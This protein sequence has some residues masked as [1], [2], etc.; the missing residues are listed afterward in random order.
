M[1]YRENATTKKPCFLSLSIWQCLIERTW[2][3]PTFSDLAER[4]T[5][6]DL[7]NPTSKLS[8]CQLSRMITTITIFHFTQKH[9]RC[10]CRSHSNS[11]AWVNTP[12][13]Q[14]S[15]IYITNTINTIFINLYQYC[16]YYNPNWSLIGKDPAICFFQALKLWTIYI[17]F[18]KKWRLEIDCTLFGHCFLPRTFLCSQM[19]FKN[20]L[21]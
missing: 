12:S 6:S 8:L 10:Q 15:S 20:I 17:I 5:P 1:L 16:Q 7:D 14:R 21:W 4:K 13:F 19:G 9:T 18:L 2:N 3:T 11:I